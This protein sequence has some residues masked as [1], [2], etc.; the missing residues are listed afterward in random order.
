MNRIQLQLYTLHITTE[1]LYKRLRLC[2]LITSIF[3]LSAMFLITTKLI[4]LI[5]NAKV[6][7]SVLLR[8]VTYYIQKF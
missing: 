5:T 4:V 8:L 3:V 6:S 1:T 2:S 7:V